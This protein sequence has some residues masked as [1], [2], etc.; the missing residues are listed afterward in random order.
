ML[1]AAH[2]RHVRPRPWASR[3]VGGGGGGG[4]LPVG[5]YRRLLPTPSLGTLF[6]DL[7]IRLHEVGNL[8][9]GA[10]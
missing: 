5:S 8:Q 9:T 4:D 6:W 2:A 1:A 10:W 7:G 3:D